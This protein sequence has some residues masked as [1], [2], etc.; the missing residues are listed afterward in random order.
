MATGLSQSSLKK[1]ADYLAPK[2]VPL[3]LVTSLGLIG[4]VRVQVSEHLVIE[5]KPDN[6]LDD[7][8]LTAPWPELTTFCES[9]QLSELDDQKHGHIPYVVIL[10]QTLQEWKKSVGDLGN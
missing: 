7:L 10:F 4:Y 9:I 3:V 5:S 2:N 1:L 8:R 6:S